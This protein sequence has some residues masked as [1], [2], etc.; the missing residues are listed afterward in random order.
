M[1]KRLKS[2]VSS[3]S[4]LPENHQFVS[5]AEEVSVPTQSLNTTSCIW[6]KVTRKPSSLDGRWGCVGH[7]CISMWSICI[8]AL[9]A[10]CIPRQGECTTLTLMIW[11]AI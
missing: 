7:Y 11:F 9:V 6:P 3:E 4:I 1:K 10:A 8:V 2:I 5:I